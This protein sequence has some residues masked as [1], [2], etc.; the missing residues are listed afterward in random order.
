MVYLSVSRL[1]LQQTRWRRDPHPCSPARIVM[2]PITLR[3][4]RLTQSCSAPRARKIGGSC[5]GMQGVCTVYFLC[6]LRN[7]DV[8]YS[9]PLLYNQKAGTSNNSRSRSLQ[10]RSTT[11]R[12]AN[13]CSMYHP[14]TSFCSCP[15]GRIPTILQPKHSGLP[16]IVLR[17]FSPL[18]HPSHRV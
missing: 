12:M 3:G 10:S 1:I 13:H 8:T 18:F 11:R 17:Y 5:S 6:V 14:E 4:I 15:T 2:K 16:W 7:S 9:F